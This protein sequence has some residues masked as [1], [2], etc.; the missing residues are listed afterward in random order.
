ML[1]KPQFVEESK[2]EESLQ[3]GKD[4]EEIEEIPQPGAEMVIASG[5]YL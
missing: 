5:K 1:T 4:E 3:L 2:G